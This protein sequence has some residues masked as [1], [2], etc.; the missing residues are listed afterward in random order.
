MHTQT[1]ARAAACGLLFAASPFLTAQDITMTRTGGGF[2]G[3]VGFPMSGPPGGV[4]ALLLSG[5]ELQTPVPGFGI[6][7]DVGLELANESFAVPGFVGTLSAAGTAEPTLGLPNLPALAGVTVS[8]QAITLTASGF[9]TTNLVRLTPQESGTFA[10]A[11]D[12]PDA[13]ILLSGGAVAAVPGGEDLVFVG[14]AGPIAQR[15]D[16]LLEEWS[17]EGLAFDVGL[18]GQATG[19]QDGRVLFSGGLDP[20][21]GQPT[22]EC[23]I[24][25]PA[26]G[27][28]TTATM[29]IPRAGH[30]A[31]L[32]DDGRV[33]VTGG[34]DAFDLADLTT[35]FGAVL[36]STEYFDPATDTFSSGPVL[37]EARALHSSTTLSD[38]A[39]LI[40]GGLS[41]LPIVSIPN[42]SATAYRFNPNTGS[43]G[44][45][46]FMG[47]PRLLHSAT[48]LD[49]G[50]VLV[51]GGLSLDLTAFLMTGDPTT[52]V[53]GTRDD[54]ELF[55]TGLFG[56]GSF[57]AVPGLM[58]TG[59]A[60]AA[61]QALD[62]GG[63]LVAG[64]LDVAVDVTNGT[65]VFETS[66][67]ADVLTRAPNLISPTGS[68]GAPRF[69]PS[70]VRL[71]D[72][73]VMVFGGGDGTA[74]IYQR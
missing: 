2:P 46:A 40:A 4:F 64:G 33:L 52:I 6:T 14:G 59:R 42:V 67:T 47:A 24:Y 7:L 23:S 3:D 1:L 18:L 72:G 26:T 51:A 38:G 27:A 39:V 12:Q 34:L 62:G 35:A 70:T 73:T 5:M 44:L 8:A 36:S 11:P 69:L 16:P 61:I 71:L 30:G 10:P 25:D 45:P 53:V 68:M 60:G 13:P 17:V 41:V 32:L 20:T 29:A 28:T 65:F 58:Q 48:A 57:A 15:Y 55:S 22:A 50:R 37:I 49:D 56:I 21:T 66:Q 54:C 19:L 43:F 31:S 74:E 63:A 9:G